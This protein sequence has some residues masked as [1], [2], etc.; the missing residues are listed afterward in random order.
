M[1]QEAEPLVEFPPTAGV[2]G[3]GSQSQPD[4]APTDEKKAARHNLPEYMGRTFPAMCQFW[5][6]TSQ[7]TSVYYTVDN[8]P[9]VGR[10]SVQF[11]V[12]IFE[13]LI[14]WADKLH[15]QLARGDQTAHHCTILQ[16]VGFLNTLILTANANTAYGI[17]RQSFNSFAPLCSILPGGRSAPAAHPQLAL[18]R[19]S[20][21]RP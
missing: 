14:A 19:Q 16:S 5:V 21:L 17:T 9:V 6:L 3:A 15:I 8:S 18:L 13:K 1:F 12:G 11:A 4:E 7:W 10:V 2:P 20:L